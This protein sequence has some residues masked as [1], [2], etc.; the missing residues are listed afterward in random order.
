MPQEARSRAATTYHS[1]YVRVSRLG[2]RRTVFPSAPD[3]FNGMR[4]PS[5]RW[6]A[7]RRATEP[8]RELRAM[9][10]P[11]GSHVTSSFPGKDARLQAKG[12]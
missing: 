12:D 5:V 4:A 2:Q 9:D 10:V 1:R 7:M 3:G 8:K 6:H 11:S